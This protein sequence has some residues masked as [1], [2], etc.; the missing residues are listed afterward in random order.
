M[1]EEIG[2]LESRQVGKLFDVVLQLAGEL[3]VAEHRLRCLELLLIRRDV[4]DAGA[5][6]R[7]TPTAEEQQVLG[8]CRDRLIGR[9]M[10][11]ITEA[12]PAEHPL[13]AQWEAMLAKS[14]TDR[15]R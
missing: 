15:D 8:E 7:F 5:L 2:Y 4:V 10:A 1:A 14:A 11:V 13:R 9:L 3:S 12:G 6:D